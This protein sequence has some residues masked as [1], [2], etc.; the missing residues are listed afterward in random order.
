MLYSIKM[1]VRRIRTSGVSYLILSIQ[2]A[3][4]ITFISY[5]TNHLFSADKMMWIVEKKVQPDDIRIEPELKDSY[6]GI[7]QCP[8]TFDEYGQIRQMIEGQTELNVYREELS[9]TGKGNFYYLFTDANDQDLDGESVYVPRQIFD[10][11]RHGEIVEFSDF[12]TVKDGN[13]VDLNTGNTYFVQKMTKEL[14]NKAAVVNSLGTIMYSDCMVIPANDLSD[15]VLDYYQITIRAGGIKDWQKKMNRILTMLES[16]HGDSY[17]Y[18]QQNPRKEQKSYFDYMTV[19]PRYLGKL[20]VVMLFVLIF[21]FAGILHLHVKRRE[22][23]HSVCYAMGAGSDR[24]CLELLLEI[25]SVCLSGMILGNL[26]CFIVMKVK[27]FDS[28][29]PVLYYVKT[30]LLTFAVT[31]GITLIVTIASVIKIRKL[32]PAKLLQSL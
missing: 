4:G 3:V 29:F 6:S 26:L 10:R 11:I 28:L 9:A 25:F 23:E 15:T 5:A 7:A 32:E 12:L 17:Q 8:V 30:V 19:M 2:F 16:S 31:C 14:E 1:V 27:V 18:M 20:A 22:K 13:I 21:G 24:I